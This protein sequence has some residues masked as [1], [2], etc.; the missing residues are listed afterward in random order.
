MYMT[1]SLILMQINQALV[2]VVINDKGMDPF[3]CIIC[4]AITTLVMLMITIKAM[5]MSLSAP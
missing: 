4:R 2:R 3:D 5:G 1:A